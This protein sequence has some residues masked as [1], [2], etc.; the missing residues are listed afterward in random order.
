MTTNNDDDDNDD[1]VVFHFLEWER[2][3]TMSTSPTYSYDLPVVSLNELLDI[4]IFISRKKM[5]RE[6][7]LKKH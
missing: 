1:Y 2:N 7:Q 4:S 6:I 3:H 5:K